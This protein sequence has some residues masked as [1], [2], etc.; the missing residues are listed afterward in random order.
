MKSLDKKPDKLV[1]RCRFIACWALLPLA[2]RDFDA[3]VSESMATGKHARIM[4]A[5]IVGLHADDA[6]Q[7]TP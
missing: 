4:I 2:K 1:H 3:R 7:D 5:F 6:G